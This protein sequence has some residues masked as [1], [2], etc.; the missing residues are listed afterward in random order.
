MQLTTEKQF[1]IMRD[2]GAHE[3]CLIIPLC[4]AID[5]PAILILKTYL[6]EMY[7]T[8]ENNLLL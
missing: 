6:F 2:N 1:Q 5:Q 4:N 7:L 3:V 8:N